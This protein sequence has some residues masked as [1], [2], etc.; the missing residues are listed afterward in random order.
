MLESQK[1]DPD[2]PAFLVPH[3]GEE[4]RKEA[5]EEREGGK[6][7]DTVGCLVVDALGEACLCTS[8]GGPRGKMQGRVGSVSCPHFR[9]P[10]LALD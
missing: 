3:V 9:L 1:R 7:S 4:K 2:F 5:G 6:E 10:S 8:S